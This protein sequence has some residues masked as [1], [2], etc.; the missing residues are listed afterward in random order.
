MTYGEYPCTWPG[1]AIPAHSQPVSSLRSP[2][3]PP[4]A[5]AEPNIYMR[6][7]GTVVYQNLVVR[8]AP[9]V[10]R[11]EKVLVRNCHF[12]GAGVVFE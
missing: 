11:G 3:S 6:A 8:G 2:A 7:D 9:L 10:V 12:E 5:E 1:C 4:Q